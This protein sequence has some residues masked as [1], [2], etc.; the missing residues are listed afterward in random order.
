MIILKTRS[1]IQFLI[2]SKGLLIFDQQQIGEIPWSESRCL[3]IQN[4]IQSPC[5]QIGQ[6]ETILEEHKPD[7]SSV[8]TDFSVS[9]ETLFFSLNFLLFISCWKQVLMLRRSRR[10]RIFCRSQSRKVSPLLG[11]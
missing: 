9:L 5:Q 6:S 8:K 3:K 4:V 7:P 10:S 1:A 11:N 2:V